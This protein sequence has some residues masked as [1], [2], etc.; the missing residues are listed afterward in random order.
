MAE[1]WYYTPSEVA[2]VLGWDAQYIRNAAHGLALDELPFP[3]ITHGT[4][5]QIPRA[6]F[7][8]WLGQMKG[9]KV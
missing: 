1:R 9:N 3:A 6:S 8:A 4:R 2:A 7:D 5:T